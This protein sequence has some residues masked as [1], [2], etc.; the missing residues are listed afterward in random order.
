MHA[1]ITSHTRFE[2]LYRRWEVFFRLKKES[3]IWKSLGKSLHELF[4]NCKFKIT[5]VNLTDEVQDR[6]LEYFVEERQLSYRRLTPEEIDRYLDL[7]PPRFQKKINSNNIIFPIFTPHSWLGHIEFTE[8]APPFLSRNE[9]LLIFT[10]LLSHAAIQIYDRRI[11]AD[12]KNQKRDINSLLNLSVK[13]SSTL[14]LD[15]LLDLILEKLKDVVPFDAGGIFLLNSENTFFARKYLGYSLPTIK[16]LKIKLQHGIIGKAIREKKTI[17]LDDVR[18]DKDYYDLR[19]KTLS[20]LTTPLFVGDDVIGV[21]SLESDNKNY[22]SKRDTEF[23]DAF[24]SLAAV[25]IRNAKLY[26]D[27]QIKSELESEMI[28]AAQVQAALLPEN[29]TVPD[30]YDLYSVSLP[31]LQVGGDIYDLGGTLD[32]YLLTIGDVSGKGASGAI[33]MA[34]LFAGLRSMLNRNYSVSETIFKLNNLM[35]GS[36]IP[37]KFATFFMAR[38]N[39]EKHQLSFSNAGHNPPLILRKD[40]TIEKLDAGGLVLGFIQNTQYEE[41]K[42][43]L[44][45]GDILIMYTDGLVEAQNEQYDEFGIEQLVKSVKNHRNETS[46]QIANSILVDV[47]EFI[48][49][50][51][52]Q[53]DLTLIIVK[54]NL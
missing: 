37:G 36:T 8:T 2:E 40:L 21:F 3:E 35:V 24:A 46:S 45:L 50:L 9:D 53:D 39:A 20:Q 6:I 41:E 18:T 38:L 17:I 23:L 32:N 12:W 27:S 25:A 28:N 13:L 43:S 54:R 22:F 31:S 42:I 34:V 30:G 19:A 47:R 7:L 26:R 52:L 49:P 48:K 44:N 5:K 4:G 15:S 29:Y 10:T 1:T 11:L 14:D 51:N 33:L 16:N